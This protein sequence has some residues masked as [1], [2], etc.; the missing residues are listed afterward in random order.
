[1]FAHLFHQLLKIPAA[2]RE[3]LCADRADF[4]N[5]RIFV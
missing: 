2:L 1:M 3:H 4:S 5:D